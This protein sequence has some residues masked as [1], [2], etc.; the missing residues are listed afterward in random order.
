M[1][2]P[3]G[4]PTR[5]KKIMDII[6]AHRVPYA[7]TASTGYPLD[8]MEKA[9]KARG[10]QGTKFIHVLT[11]CATGWRM[12]ERLSAQVAVLAVETRLFPL[13][14]VFEGKR[15]ALTHEHEGR[16]VENYLA[17]QGRYRHL[18]PEQVRVMQ[19]EVDEEWTALLKR[20]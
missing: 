10:I 17:I 18:T 1:T 6:A 9:E 16:P 7:A 20:L 13:Y 12:E 11:P 4:R 2:T 14:E 19:A 8:L 3:A 5:K 15:Y